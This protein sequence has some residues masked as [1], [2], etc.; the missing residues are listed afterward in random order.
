MEFKECMKIDS[1]LIL[2]NRRQKVEV[3]A[4]STAQNFFS[5]WRT[6]KHGV[7]QV[8]VLG[9][10]LFTTYMSDIPLIINAT[11][12]PTLFVDNTSVII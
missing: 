10:L 4:P 2:T 8:L 6:L 9:P 5:D 1:G 3:K 12:E 7:P 11:S